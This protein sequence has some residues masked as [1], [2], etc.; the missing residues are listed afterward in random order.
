MP[1]LTIFSAPKAFTNTHIAMIQRNAIRSW[2][3]LPDVEVILLGEELGLLETARELGVRHVPGVER[4]E[5]GTPLISSMFR[6]AREN[7][8][9]PLLAIVNADIIVMPDLVTAA[10]RA[11]ELVDQFVLLGRRW[12]K[13]VTG[14]LDFSNSW[15]TLLRSSVLDGGALHSP[16]GSDYFLFPRQCFA[17][18]PPFAIGRSGWDNWMIYRARHEKWPVIDCTPS[19]MVVH[20]NHDYGHLPGGEP[21]YALPETDENIRLAGGHAAVRYTILDSTHRLVDGRLISPAMDALRLTRGLELFLRRIFFFLPAAATE[22]AVRPRR[23]KKRI[24]R[25]L[26]NRKP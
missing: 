10:R 20:Q 13:D 19:V 23:W 11:T 15:Q 18:V 1:F 3:L 7:S 14:A 2:T 6:L 22:Q 5:N 17:H 21:H 9:S 8:L 16:G 26:G 4:N 25:L 12:D 24:Q